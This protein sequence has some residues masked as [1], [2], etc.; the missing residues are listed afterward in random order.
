M[1]EAKSSAHSSNKEWAKYQSVTDFITYFK[2][3]IPLVEINTP[4]EKNKWYLYQTIY[5][6]IKRLTVPFCQV[7]NCQYGTFEPLHE[8]QKKIP[9]SIH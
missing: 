8:I 3:W 6:S 9:K 5:L 7:K 4:S 2:F 1:V